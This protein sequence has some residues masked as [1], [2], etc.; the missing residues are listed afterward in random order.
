MKKLLLLPA[1]VLLGCDP[2]IENV[3]PPTVV[4]ARFDPSAAPLVVPAPNDLATNPKTG[5]LAVP[6]PAGASGADK[7]F[8]AFLNS[9]NG[10]PAAATATTTFD[11]RLSAETVK[12][13]SVKVLD[14]SDNFKD[15]T[16]TTIAYSD[17]DSGAAKGQ[18][19]ITAPVGGWTTGHSYAIALVGGTTGLKGA[20]GKTPVVGSATWAFIRSSKPLVTC[21]DL[22]S[23]DCHTAT[24]TIPSDVTD[25][26]A[27]R[28]AD[29]TGKALQLEQ[30]RLH[31]QPILDTLVSRGIAREDVAIAW[32][33]KIA[34][35]G[36]IVFN[37]SATPPAVPTPTDL[38]KS[39]TTGLLTVPVDPTSPPANQEFINDYL[40]TLNGFPTATTAT[41]AVAGGDLDPATVNADTV[42]VLTLKGEPVVGATIAYDAANKQITVAPPGGSWGKSKIIGIAIIGGKNGVKR[43]GGGGVV[44]SEIW[45]L[46]RSA[47]PLVDCDDLTSPDCAS[48]VTA[49]PLTL[50][51]ATQLEAVRRAYAPVLDGLE[52]QGV[53]R[54]D[55]A[56]LWVFSTVDRPEATFDPA[57]SIVPFPTDLLRTGAG[58]HLALPTPAGAPATLAAL[59]GGLNTLDG[60]SLTATAVSENSDT[61]GVI[62]GTL[63]VT[64]TDGGIGFRQLAGITTPAADV[65]ICFNCTS[66]AL[67]DGGVQDFPQQLQIVPN[68]PLNEQSTYGAWMT[69][70]LQDTDGRKVMASP[71]FALLRLKNPLCTDAAAGVCPAGSKSTVSGVSDA[72]AVQLEP[73]RAGMKPFFDGLETAGL[74]RKNLALAWTWKT[75][76]TVSILQNL[77]DAAQSPAWGDDPTFLFDIS[78]QV[79][80]TL[81]LPHSHISK[82][83]TGNIT[84]PFMLTGTDAANRP[85]NTINPDVTKW[86][87]DKVPFWLTIP[88]GTVPTTGWPVMI[89]GHGLNGNR[90]QMIAIADAAAGRGVATIAM[91]VVLHGERTSCVG[92]GAAAQ[93]GTLTGMP[94]PGATDD[95]ACATGSTCD[96]TTGRCIGATHPACAYAGPGDLQCA[97]VA[98]GQCR[99]DNTCEGG[100]FKRASAGAAPQFASWNFLNLNNFFAT[101]DDFRHAVADFGHLVKVIKSNSATSLSAQLGANGALDPTTIGY[102]AIS[103]GG[104]NGALFSAVSPDVKNIALNVP[105]S[106][107]T[108]VLLLSPAFAA[109]RAGFLN[110]LAGLGV[111][112]GSPA[113][114][115]FVVLLKT[116]VDGCDGQNTIYSGVNRAMPAGR[117]VF[118]Q[119]IQNDFVVPNYVTDE[120]IKAS[121]L[122]ST[123]LH[124]YNPTLPADFTCTSAPAGSLC[125][126]DRHGFLLNFKDPVLT[127]TA[128]AEVMNF[129]TTGAP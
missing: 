26:A 29:Q 94:I 14:I 111:K 19:S 6:V 52:E 101:R 113:F 16:G 105:G 95:L 123:N 35:L 115:N 23:P 44:G 72:Q 22:T 89:F 43:V 30:L 114:D 100:D 81:P 99:P 20:D 36:Q 11:G 108:N 68:R 96:A 50:A 80:A 54:T 112:P 18:V 17:I 21:T 27:R 48:N 33:F 74:L 75:Q 63:D 3:A 91:D 66:S 104:F 2:N 58:G 69:T 56:V 121:G 117:K 87:K 39:Q 98:A 70:A 37:P 67:A 83:F 118:I 109:Q 24:E 45:A 38:V 51:Q 10:Y 122:P 110:L 78:A 124:R 126:G 106:D 129:V 62:D 53:A 128:Q 57:H 79:L 8:Y 31:Y 34:D 125:A 84:T 90:T 116:V 102:S 55:V 7:A 93:A 64:A 47:S 82:L 61:I 88:T 42:V 41:A 40:N 65:K 15:V 86:R 12:P 85:T 1:L 60:F 76:S 71:T 73:A 107:L 120:L 97:A 25:D 59:I 4:T 127:S 32:S 77:H 103:L 119:S 13:D 5:L 46:A 92:I 28:L 49:A 9:L